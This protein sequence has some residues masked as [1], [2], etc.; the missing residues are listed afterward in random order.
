MCDAPA[1]GLRD[2]MFEDLAL[3]VRKLPDAADVRAAGYQ[4]VVPPGKAAVQEV[5]ANS[6]DRPAGFQADPSRAP[7]N[8]AGRGPARPAVP[9]LD[10]GVLDAL[11]ASLGGHSSAPPASTPLPVGNESRLR[12]AALGITG[13]TAAS[14]T[15]GAWSDLWPESPELIDRL[16]SDPA[17]GWL[18]GEIGGEVIPKSLG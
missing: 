9:A 15:A 12:P 14:G 17:G 6:G 18:R 4:P 1:P 3:G 11:V 13:R 16:F 2:V 5:A 8:A 10:P 7:A